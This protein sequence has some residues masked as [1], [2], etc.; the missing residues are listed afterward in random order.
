MRSSYTA[1]RIF[2]DYC[3][4]AQRQPMLAHEPLVYSKIV[5]VA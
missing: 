5:P 1:K 2:N 4:S 3:R